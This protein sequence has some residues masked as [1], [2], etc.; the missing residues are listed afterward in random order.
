MKTTPPSKPAQSVMTTA[1]KTCGPSSELYPYTIPPVSTP[2]KRSTYT[3]CANSPTATRPRAPHAPWTGYA[4]NGSS[5]R[6]RTNALAASLYVAAE[7]T[8]MRMAKP[9]VT[10]AQPAVTPTSPARIPYS[11][12]STDT[13]TNMP[14]SSWVRRL[15]TKKPIKTHERAQV[16][17]ASI[18]FDAMR[19]R[20]WPAKEPP[21]YM[22]TYT[23]TLKATHPIDSK[24]VPSVAMCSDDGGR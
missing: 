5:I 20:S 19:P 16:D 14:S 12:S 3:G 8:P 11:A 21:S 13:P 22:T 18:V 24:K 7:S 10:R 4:F 2:Y 9:G 23:P 15:E 1:D 6:Q 17:D